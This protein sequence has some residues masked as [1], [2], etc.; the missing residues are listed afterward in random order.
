MYSVTL[1]SST[2]AR[3]DSKKFG[4]RSGALISRTE[5]ERGRSCTA[6]DIIRGGADKGGWSCLT[7]WAQGPREGPCPQERDLDRPSDIPRSGFSWLFGLLEKNFL[8][9]SLKEP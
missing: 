8:A 7:F 2:A 1:I 4:A 6:G 9:D 3:R 5:V